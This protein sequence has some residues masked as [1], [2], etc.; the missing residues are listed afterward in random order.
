MIHQVDEFVF[1]EDVQYTKRD[2]RNRNIIKTNKGLK[3]ITVPVENNSRNQLIYE[4]KINNNEQWARSHYDIIRQNY[5]YA[6]YFKQYKEFLEHI[7]FDKKFNT[8]SELNIYTT[9]L[10]ARKLGI[11]TKFVNSVDLCTT[12][13]KDDKLIAICKQLQATH[14][15]S[16]PAA[17]E[18]IDE[19]KF[20]ENNITLE[21]IRYEYPRYKQVDEPFEHGVTILDLIL[22]CG[23]DALNYVLGNRKLLNKQ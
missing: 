17:K 2:W 15:I 20:K 23:D 10:I 5:F 11:S 7:Y 16:G 19:D 6:P 13:K 4:V 9:T 3:W 12:G 14:Y 1:L 21:Y 22:N 18:Y 8:L